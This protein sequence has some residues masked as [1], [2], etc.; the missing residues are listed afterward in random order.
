MRVTSIDVLL[1]PEEHPT[2]AN[3]RPVLCRVNTDEGIYGY[4][5]AGTT[6][7]VGSDAV[8]A[9]MKELAPMVIGMSPMDTEV[10]WEKIYK[11]A[12]WTRG[13]GAI[14]SAALSA[15]DTALWDIKGKALGKPVYELLGG[16]FRDKLRCYASQLQFGFYDVMQPQFTRE[17][18]FEVAKI[19]VEK[20]YDAVKLDPMV[21]GA[22]PGDLKL[23][24]EEGFGYFRHKILRTIGERI[25]ATREAVGQDADIIVEM[26]CSTDLQT[27]VQV[28][29]VCE[30]FDIM[31]LEE[32]VDPLI[33]ETTKRLS[34][35]T[36][37]PL[38]TGERTYLRA[39]FLPFLQ[40]RSLSMIQ[41]DI[42]IC[43]GITE[44]KKIADMAYSYQ[45]GVQAH[46]C[47]T[48]IS[49]AAGVQ[50]EAAIANFTIH[51]THV[52]SVM[53]GFLSLGVHNDFL[54]VNGYIT[55][56]DRPGIGQE[57]SEEAFRRAVMNTVK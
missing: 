48:P 7:F 38:T 10:V 3:T 57:L 2:F 13:N 52:S 15:I 12:Y 14:I 39:G 17:Q 26:H 20:G 35:A 29:K 8:F 41:P 21:F 53:S 51:E 55:V 24:A 56:P 23:V 47:G 34:Q 32:P 37:I 43:G 4:G 22:A 30:P 33:P 44:C 25:Q 11:S 1:I 49:V 31:Y 45:V 6:F 46:V 19:A 42:G 40:D 28:A 50:L 54:P 27:A 9:M 16:K 36:S 18:Y 5:E